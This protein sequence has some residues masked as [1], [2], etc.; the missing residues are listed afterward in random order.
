MRT[1]A[2]RYR[3]PLVAL[4]SVVVAVL[5]V[6][7]I[8]LVG[9]S[10][11]PNGSPSP[12]PVSPSPSAADPG[13]TPEGATR[14]F[15]AAFAE[16]RRTDDPTLVQAFVTSTGSS[17]YKSVEGFLLGQK[18]AGKASITTVLRLENVEVRQ[19][20][21]TATVTFDYTE[22]GYDM[23]FE[24]GQPLESPVIL[25]VT[26]VT[27]ELQQIDGRWLVERYESR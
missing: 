7:A 9:G 21:T 10:P 17:A 12:M 16:A 1:I 20:G 15:F 27:V 18:A 2:E 4:A 26:Q 23:D 3:L 13:S 24:S 14:A 6:G 19:S 5:V 22:G 8:L 11:R 25:P